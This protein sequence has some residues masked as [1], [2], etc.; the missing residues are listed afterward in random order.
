MQPINI[1]DGSRRRAVSAKLLCG[2]ARICRVWDGYDAT[3]H[4]DWPATH[5]NGP[6]HPL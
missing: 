4:G 6:S 5:P 3:V 2:R 1:L